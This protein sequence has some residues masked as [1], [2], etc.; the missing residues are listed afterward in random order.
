M[1]LILIYKAVKRWWWIG[2]LPVIVVT[3]YLTASYQQPGATYGV[4]LRFATGGQPTSALSDD[5]DRYYPWL[6][7]EYIANGLADIATFGTF[8]DLVSDSLAN[9]HLDIQPSAVRNAISSDNTQSTTFI[10]IT[11][12][13]PQEAVQLAE[14]ISEVLI[15]N[16]P[17]FYPQMSQIGPVAR[18]VDNPVAYPLPTSLRA[19][20]MGPFIRFG[21]AVTAGFGLLLAVYF[22][23]PTVR[24]IDDITAQ[25][26]PFLGSI[27]RH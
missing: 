3:A 24:E 22:L 8:A 26:I 14:A 1:D 16:A 13:N 15:N 27:P 23:D 19:Q 20:L 12:H 18:L 10:Y 21:L 2:I 9:R 25:A 4:T 5:Y 17:V 6:S 11:W 7:S